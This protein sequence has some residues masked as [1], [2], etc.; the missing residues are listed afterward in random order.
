MK[1]RK[2]T[3]SKINIV[4]RLMFQIM[5]NKEEKYNNDSD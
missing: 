2:L 5:A 1:N 4:E 3:A